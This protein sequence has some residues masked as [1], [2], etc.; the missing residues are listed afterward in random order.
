M[1]V[2]KTLMS[3]VL[4]F[5]SLSLMA[6]DRPQG[7]RGE[8]GQRNAQGRQEWTVQNR[9]ERETARIHQVVNLSDKQIA[10]VYKV[11]YTCALQDSVQMA[12]VRAEREQGNTQ[13][14]DREAFRKQY[15]ERNN[16]KKE[17]L[18]A[19]F[20]K[21]QAAAYEKWLQEMEQRRQQA[22]QNR[23]GGERGPRN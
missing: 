5:A 19:I 10:D 9:A 21:E 2:L 8:R 15:E 4:A 23:Q 7:P 14:F 13:N 11:L 6:Q 16:I 18:N 22:R 17:A 20:T 3:I 12:K 1:K